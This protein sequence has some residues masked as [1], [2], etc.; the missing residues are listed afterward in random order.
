MK[1]TGRSDFQDF[2]PSTLAVYCN[3]SFVNVSFHPHLRYTITILDCY[4]TH[5]NT[6]QILP[7][8]TEYSCSL[9]NRHPVI[10]VISCVEEKNDKIKIV[11][12]FSAI[13][14]CFV[15]NVVNNK[16]IILLNFAE[17]P[18]TLNYPTAPSAKY[19]AIFRTI[20]QDNCF[21]NI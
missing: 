11:S 8:C 15:I 1:S 7:W 13:K 21:K 17:N 5:C 4:S 10:Y 6:A 16:T 14:L 3:Y 18:L 19:Q 20:S 2:T 9:V 12:S